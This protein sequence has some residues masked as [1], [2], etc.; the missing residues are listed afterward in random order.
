MQTL[1]GAGTTSRN[2]VCEQCPPGRHGGPAGAVACTVCPTSAPY[3]QAG[4]RSLTNCTSCATGCEDGTY[5]AAW[6]LGSACPAGHACSVSSSTRVSGPYRSRTLVMCPHTSVLGS[7]G[8]SSLM[9][10][11]CRCE[12]ARDSTAPLVVAPVWPVRGAP[13]PPPAA[14]HFAGPAQ[15]RL[16]SLCGAVW[17]PWRA[18]A[19]WLLPAVPVHL[20]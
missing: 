6:D 3:S 4:S 14:Q 19:P 7:R 2:G 18:R 8:W 15:Q 9:S 1:C 16:L 20:R 13:T 5:G 12:V 10:C 17:H 11:C